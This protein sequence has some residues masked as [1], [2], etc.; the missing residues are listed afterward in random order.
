MWSW[1]ESNPRPN[2]VL[3]VRI[4]SIPQ[5][6]NSRSRYELPVHNT[7]AWC[8]LVGIQFWAR[9]HDIVCCPISLYEIYPYH[10]TY[11]RD[12][13][14]GTELFLNSHS[15]LYTRSGKAVSRPVCEGLGCTSVVVPYIFHQSPSHTGRSGSS[16]S[17]AQAQ[18]PFSAPYLSATCRREADGRITVARHVIV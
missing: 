2:I 17:F 11:P 18:N 14:K 12:Q 3:Q 5:R 7:A 10:P 15:I 1:R 4:R 9:L 8:V 16:Q 13:V 6:L